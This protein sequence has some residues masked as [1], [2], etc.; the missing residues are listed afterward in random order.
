MFRV[1]D[2]SI[3]EGPTDIN[4][5]IFAPTTTALSVAPVRV[6]FSYTTGGSLMKLY[7]NAWPNA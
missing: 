5:N 6:I 7:H 4:F 3:P 2:L 1:M